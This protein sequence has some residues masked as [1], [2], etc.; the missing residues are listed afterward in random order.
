MDLESPADPYFYAKLLFLVLAVS[1]H[2]YVMLN[3]MPRAPELNWKMI[4]IEKK[5]KKVRRS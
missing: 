5:K 4:A 2:L 1:I 3:D